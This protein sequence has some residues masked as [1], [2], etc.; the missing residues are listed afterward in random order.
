MRVGCLLP[1]TLCLLCLSAQLSSVIGTPPV[2]TYTIIQSQDNHDGST[3]SV[4]ASTTSINREGYLT[5]SDSTPQTAKATLGSSTTTQASIY[6]SQ[7]NPPYLQPGFTQDEAQC[8]P[9]QRDPKG[10]SDVLYQQGYIWLRNVSTI[11]NTTTRDN[12]MRSTRCV[13]SHRFKFVFHH[14]LKNAGSTVTMLLKLAIGD[15]LPNHQ[16]GDPFPAKSG[17]LPY[18]SKGDH[19]L[20]LTSCREVYRLRDYLHFAFVRDP[21]ARLRSIVAFAESWRLPT[22]TYPRPLPSVLELARAPDPMQAL[23]GSTT[24]AVAHAVSQHAVLISSNNTW[25]VD[26]IADVGHLVDAFRE[27]IIP[28]LDVRARQQGIDPSPLEKLRAYLSQDAQQNAMANKLPVEGLEAK[29]IHC[30]LFK[31][32]YRRDYE[33]FFARHEEEA[34][35]KQEDPV[36]PDYSISPPYDEAMT[37]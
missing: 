33:L 8:F 10:I 11:S 29:V 5:T 19:W 25:S 24:M 16:V 37:N 7:S 22:A 17:R 32:Y 6:S 26:F 27:H 21:Y 18:S 14:V 15:V 4:T 28:V 13:V 35:A 1:A 2:D 23:V 9:P 3:T 36:L 30:L 34:R 31:G 20:L 12:A